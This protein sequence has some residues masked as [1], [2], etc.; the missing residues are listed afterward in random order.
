[1]TD[2]SYSRR[3]VQHVT[4]ADDEF[5]A[6]SEGRIRIRIGVVAFAIMIVLIVLRLAETS[7]FG[8]KPAGSTLPQA[9]TTTRAD[10]TDRNGE[11]LATTLLTY[12][13]YAEPHIVWNVE[14]TADALLSVLP[15]L[16]RA[17]LVEH[18]GSKK[19]FEWIARGLTP[20]ERQAVFALGQP[21]LGFRQEP[22]RVYPRGTLASHIVGYADVG[23]VGLAGAERA[24][25]E[26]L[27]KPN[28]PAKALSID[29]RVQY[30]VADSLMHGIERYSAKSAAGVVMD[31][32]TGEII[33]MASVP[34]FDPNA[35]A[36]A[37]TESRFN[38][39]AMSTYELGSVFKPITM[40]LALETQTST[41][42]EKFPVQKPFKVTNKFIR[43]DHPSKVP[44][45]MPEILSQS[46]NRGTA[47][48]AL[49]AG[50]DA[51][52]QMLRDFGLFDRV[53]Y[54]L[55]ES[56]RPQVQNRWIDLTT[57][58]VSYGH[59]IAVT[60]LALAVASAPL[61]NGGLYVTPTI[62]KRDAAN[63]VASRRV[64]S[65]STAKHVR[66]MMR[67]VVTDGTGRNARASGY[68]VMGKTGTADKPGVGGYDDKGDIVTSFISG[69]PYADPRYV[70]M[71]TYDSPQTVEG[72]WGYR[73]AGWNAAK[74]TKD[75][76]ERIAPMLAIE[77]LDAAMAQKGYPA[78]EAYR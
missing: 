6:V 25:H 67:Y 17:E 1:M 34:E 19:N 41:L 13:L 40:A 26:E 70:V 36:T 10:I 42:T 48:L 33:A 3:N 9:I 11:V 73:G 76:V 14:E 15:E 22:K 7:I 39:A 44:L 75:V 74:T 21:G 64:L 57:V 56:A 12:S 66:D 31:M 43:D 18:L 78:Q 30:A 27:S 24:F 29:M 77:R 45:A 69:F 72:D 47:M 50:A 71:I 51:Q 46:S 55:Y 20:K 23:M 8:P 62:L 63:P 28:A 61:M 54:E 37:S 5:Q 38:H 4:V 68:G 58:T 65:D 60:P 2:P 52:K 35:P 59:G 53:P 16:D 32:K 49:R